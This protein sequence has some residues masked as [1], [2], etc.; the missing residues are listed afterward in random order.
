[1]KVTLRADKKKT[2]CGP[3]QDTSLLFKDSRRCPDVPVW[4]DTAKHVLCVCRLRDDDLIDVK[5]PR[6]LGVESAP[7]K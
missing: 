3:F 7:V 6:A 2:L 1:M 5:Q 4:S